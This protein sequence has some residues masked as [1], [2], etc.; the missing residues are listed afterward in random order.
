MDMPRNSPL[1]PGRVLVTLLVALLGGLVIV[2][3]SSTQGA[4]AQEATQNEAS[5]KADANQRVH[6]ANGK[7][8]IDDTESGTVS[9]FEFN[10]KN[11]E[12]G[13][14]VARGKLFFRNSN[15]SDSSSAEGRIEC[16]RV[17]KVDGN[18]AGYFVLRVTESSGTDAPPVGTP[19]GINIVDTGKENGK[20]DRVLGGPVDEPAPCLNPSDEGMRL[21]KGNITIE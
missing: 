5:A 9:K 21:T 14:D 4:D 7:G 8:R 2:S 3:L 20:G 6:S 11:L 1:L 13:S 19:I 12:G 10:A 15:G 17:N 16:L 18:K